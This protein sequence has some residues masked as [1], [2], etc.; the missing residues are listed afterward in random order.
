[1]N[2]TKKYELIRHILKGEKTPKKYSEETGIPLSTIYYYLKRFREGDGNI[3]SLT[4]KSHTNQSH[5]RW[6]TQVDK[7]KVIQHK[8]Q[9]PHLSSRQ[10]AEALV[11][12]GILQISYP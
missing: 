1:V 4:D 12:E 6:L 9:N 3:E 10:I 8:L 7:E 5:P 11:Q 2:A